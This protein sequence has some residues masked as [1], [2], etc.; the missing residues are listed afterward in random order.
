[1]PNKLNLDDVIKKVSQKVNTF[2]KIR[3]FMKLFKKLID[4]LSFFVS[5]SNYCP[6]VKVATKSRLLARYI[7]ILFILLFMTLVYPLENY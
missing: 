4:E 2:S 1:M 3:P 5:Q 7:H 6:F